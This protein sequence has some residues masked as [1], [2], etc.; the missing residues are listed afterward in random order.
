MVT[1]KLWLA[2]K[3]VLFLIGAYLS[4]QHLESYWFVGP[5]FGGVVLVWSA[6]TLRDLFTPSSGAYL[7]ASTLIYAFV[8]QIVLLAP[9]LGEYD[10]FVGVFVG[11]VL[12]PVAHALFLKAAWTRALVAVPGVYGSWALVWFIMERLHV[13]GMPIGTFINLVSVWQ[14]AYLVFMFAPNPAGLARR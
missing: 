5:V 14:A 7:V 4:G 11:T 9:L 10:V 6:R 2:A 13:E 1:P 3:I 12:L 8:V